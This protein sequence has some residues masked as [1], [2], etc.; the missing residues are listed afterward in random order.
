MY[1]V[2]SNGTFENYDESLEEGGEEEGQSK[3]PV[4]VPVP[5]LVPAKNPTLFNQIKKIQSLNHISDQ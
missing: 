4:P 3:S 2:I 5:V 1:L